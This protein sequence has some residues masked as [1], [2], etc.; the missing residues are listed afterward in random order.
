MQLNG[1]AATYHSTTAV[2]VYSPFFD[3]LL[4]LSIYLQGYRVTLPIKFTREIEPGPLKYCPGIFVAQC[5]CA[6]FTML[7]GKDK[8]GRREGKWQGCGSA[9]GGT[10]SA[11]SALRSR[12]WTTKIKVAI[13][14]A[15]HTAQCATK[16]V[17]RYVHI[18]S[19]NPSPACILVFP[20]SFPNLAKRKSGNFLVGLSKCVAFR[21]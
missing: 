15:L 10:L 17:P 16:C 4:Q 6:A 19:Q 18:Y 7:H 2:C 14:M 12:T 21:N 13:E 3:Y 11:F 9:R 1:A 20:H 5:C 8:N